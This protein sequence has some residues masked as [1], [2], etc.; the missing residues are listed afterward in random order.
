MHTI[1]RGTVNQ[2]CPLPKL[3]SS[4]GTLVHNRYAQL[5]DNLGKRQIWSKV[6]PDSGLQ[7]TETCR[8]PMNDRILF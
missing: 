7:N 2:I 4:V 1:I 8:E 6:T 3:P 5:L